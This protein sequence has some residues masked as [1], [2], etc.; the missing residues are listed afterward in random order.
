MS[1]KWNDEDMDTDA[2]MRKRQAD[3]DSLAV[4]Y[5]RG[6]DAF[7][8]AIRSGGDVAA[9]TTDSVRALG[10]ELRAQDAAAK[11][12][13]AIRLGDR[14]ALSDKDIAAI[15]FNETRSF[16]GPDVQ[17]AREHLAHAIMNAD[18]TWGTDRGRDAKSAPTSA[19]PPKVELPTYQSSIDA[20][21]SARAQRLKGVDP[22][23]GALNFR[24]TTTPTREPFVNRSLKAQLPVHNSYTMGDVP[25]ASAYVNVY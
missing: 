17:R 16:S 19:N 7:A 14:A 20:V 10:A 6:R 22:T 8:S 11:V 5:E 9:P 15:I 13:Q 21:A 23:S 18:E 1:E 24:F 4:D 25:S 2:W 12:A 3:V